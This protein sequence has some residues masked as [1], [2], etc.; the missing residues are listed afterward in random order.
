VITF[1]SG[2]AF[3]L[4]APLSEF[5]AHFWFILDQ[6]TCLIYQIKVCIAYF[7]FSNH[8]TTLKTIM[9]SIFL[10][11][12]NLVARIP[13]QPSRAKLFF[14]LC[15]N[16]HNAEICNIC[17][18]GTLQANALHE[19]YP[20]VGIYLARW[21]ELH[22]R[23]VRWFLLDLDLQTLKANVCVFRLLPTVLPGVQPRPMFWS[24]LQL[25]I[26]LYLLEFGS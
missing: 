24:F 25:W 21:L 15:K 3:F 10:G 2:F 1:I 22:E 20:H 13:I 11:P 19:R 23:T 4:T 6:K 17:F 16:Y 18:I 26:G 7:S 5:T 14:L 9:C 12:F 8:S